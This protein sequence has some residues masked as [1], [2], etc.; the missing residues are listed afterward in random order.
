MMMFRLGAIGTAIA[1]VVSG[2]MFVPSS[3]AAPAADTWEFAGTLSAPARSATSVSVAVSGTVEVSQ[4]ILD[5]VPVTITCTSPNKPQVL[6]HLY[7][8]SDS[9]YHSITSGGLALTPIDDTLPASISGSATSL[10]PSTYELVLRFRCSNGGSWQ[11]GIT[12]TPAKTVTIA[13][14]TSSSHVTHACLT[15]AVSGRCTG[16]QTQ[17]TKVPSGT[18]VTFGATITQVWS[19]GVTTQ[20]AVTGGQSLTRAYTWSSSFSSISSACDYTTSITSDYQYRCEAGGVQFTPVTVETIYA[21]YN[22]QVAAPTLTPA[23]AVKGSLVTV[24][25]TVLEEYSDGSYWPASTS[26]SYSVQFQATGSSTWSTVVSSRNLSTAG[27]YSATFTMTGPGQVRTVVSSTNSTPVTLTE[28]TPTT[29]YQIGAP[30]IASEV[31]PRVAIAPTASVKLLWSDGSYR[32]PTEGTEATLEFAPSFDP[33]AAAGSLKWRTIGKASATTGTATFSATPQASGFWRASVGSTT[34]PATYVR[35]TGSAVSTLSA[36]MSPAPGQQPFV[37]AL[38]NYAI[39]ATLTGY[40]GTDPAVLFVDMGSGFERVTTFD[41]NGTIN[42]TFPVRAGST[43]GDITPSLQARDPAGEVLATTS[44]TPIYVDGIKTYEITVVAPTQ[45]VREGAEVNITATASGISSTGTRYAVPWS[46][47]VQVQR[48]TGSSWA[49]LTTKSD[50]SGDRLTLSMLAIDGAEYR[51]YW[52]LHAT[53]SK[54]FTLKVMTPSG[55]YRF[56]DARLSP[57]KAVKGDSVK[58]SVRVMAEYSDKKFY[59]APD[60]TKVRLQSLNGG[61][62]RDVKAVFVEDGRA[63]VGIRASSTQSFRFIGPKDVV[64]KTMT[65]TVTVPQATKLV[66]DWPS[67]YY[68]SEGGEFTVYIKTNTGSVW[69]GTTTLQL[70]YRYSTSTGFTLLDTRTYKGRKFTWGWGSGPARAVQ[71]RVYAP[72]LGLSDSQAYSPR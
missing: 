54:P 42:G 67:T 29:T 69:T 24:S 17:Y 36:T 15:S 58:I 1:V 53:G 9:T 22:Y 37:G 18:S 23:Y 47:D 30:T 19:D 55:D 31:A 40:V 48:K 39:N 32:N 44:T 12:A 6:P 45:P 28:L 43:S 38:A 49:T 34:G 33:S 21:R 72:N 52:P 59:S 51:V 11:G 56:L 41:T 71:F 14:L 4:E 35:V 3:Q 63:T 65:L 16:N 5:R 7:R 27:A 50:T 60:G 10:T 57:S 61:S 66:V 62:W 64:S 25:G 20:E 2:F 70:G 8:A 68:I 26:T 13:S 46:G